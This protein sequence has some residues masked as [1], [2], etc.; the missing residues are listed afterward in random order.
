MATAFYFFSFLF[1]VI[2]GSFLNVVIYRYNTGVSLGGRSMCMSC[3][4][5]LSWHELIPVVS[6][7]VQKRKCAN[8][9]SRVSAQYP[10][11]EL[12][13]GLLFLLVFYSQYPILTVTDVINTV[14][15]SIVM[16]LL[17][18]ITVYDWKHKIIP[19]GL[20]YTF[21]ALS[22]GIFLFHA[23]LPLDRLSSAP[24]MLNMLAGP[25]LATP[26]ALL[27]LLSH[28]RWMGLG[29]AKLALG[30]GWFLGLYSAISAIILAFWIGS[31]FGIGLLV[32][33]RVR[34]LF[35]SSKTFTMKSEI[36]FG[37]FL[38]LG[39]LLVF[40]FHID[41]LSFSGVFFSI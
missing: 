10:A 31:L 14:F 28:G 23:G 8:C 26:F 30:I 32:L 4:K 29:D 33:S 40:F 5:R 1:G 12:L 2:I 21:A 27:W 17:V 38:V 25:I 19:D 35:S 34:G 37:P 22:F 15:Y 9:G 6:F 13:T 3:G 36:P 18:V 41:V 20:V 39:T 7:L 24:Y 16:S 11:T